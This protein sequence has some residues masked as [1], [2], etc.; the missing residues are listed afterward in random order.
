MKETFY[1]TEQVVRTRT[2]PFG[3]QEFVKK[4]KQHKP[5]KLVNAFY[6]E[7]R[8]LYE[9][10]E[11]MDHGVKYF[12]TAWADKTPVYQHYESFYQSLCYEGLENLYFEAEVHEG[13]APLQ[14]FADAIPETKNPKGP[15]TL[16]RHS[17]QE[18]DHVC[19]TWVNHDG[20]TYHAEGVLI[21]NP[22]TGMWVESSSGIT[23]VRRFWTLYKQLNQGEGVQE[24][25]ATKMNSEPNHDPKK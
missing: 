24:C 15:F 12:C 21:N 18:G 13:R 23:E 9:I 3:L 7:S 2:I 11:Y 6:S 14:S 20:R 5:S 17:F 19:G 16:G 22:V 4:L 25:D 10:V 1:T 8:P